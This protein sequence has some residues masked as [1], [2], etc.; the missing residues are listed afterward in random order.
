MRD[1]YNQT[2]R[3]S[4]LLY[5]AQLQEIMHEETAFALFKLGRKYFESGGKVAKMP[6]IRHKQLEFKHLIPKIYDYNGQ[7]IRDPM[8]I[9]CC[10]KNI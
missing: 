8:T 6:T 2:F 3:D 1:P 10:F 7:P 4:L 5:R 9:N